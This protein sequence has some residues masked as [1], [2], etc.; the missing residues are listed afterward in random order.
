MNFNFTSIIYIVVV[1]LIITWVKSYKNDLIVLKRLSV[2]DS[3]FNPLS[4]S[5]EKSLKL[6]R[7]LLVSVLAY[8][9]TYNFLSKP[10]SIYIAS[11]TLIISIVIIILLFL[12]KF[13]YMKLYRNF[14]DLHK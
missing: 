9:F 11:I 10:I 13:R 7:N 3:S 4:Y 14:K 12:E 5:K 8:I 6:M 2:D 1:I